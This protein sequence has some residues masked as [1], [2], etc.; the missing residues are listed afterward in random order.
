MKAAFGK[1]SITPPI[2]DTFPDFFF[3]PEGVLDEIYARVAILEADSSPIVMVTLDV[4]GIGVAEIADLESAI[5]KDVIIATERIWITGSHSHSAPILC[6]IDLYGG[7][8]PYFTG[9]KDRL[10]SLIATLM[11]QLQPVTIQFGQSTCDFNV[12]RRLIDANGNCRMAPNPS[13]VVDKSVPVIAFRRVDKTLIGILFSYCC[14][15]TILLGP[16]ISGDYPGWAQNTLEKKYD[17]AVA[18]FLPGV[19]GNVRPYLN[20]GDHFRPGTESEAISCGHVLAKAVED[21]IENCH[22]LTVNALNAWRSTP[23][24][25][26][27]KPLSKDELGKIAAQSI[28]FQRASNPTQT[29]QDGF[30]IAQRQWVQKVRLEQI[31]NRVPTH[32]KYTFSRL[33]LGNLNLVGLSGEFFLEYG[34]HAQL[35]RGDE[36]TLVFGYTQG[37]QTYVPTA[38]ALVQGGYEVHAYK[39]W[40]QSAPFKI[41][42]EDVVKNGISD[43]MSYQS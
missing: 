27:D 5:S 10:I 22:Y 3:H 30:N 9:L 42:V 14:H 13:G 1:I 7:F 31:E 12:N 2:N 4:L 17:S 19:F 34:I 20:S 26:L 6:P 37:C 32:Q 43:L 11:L 36:K 18:L 35:Q 28:T 40:K 23:H 21:G 39:R 8:S 16:K 33:Q 29:W 38:E 24:L 41:E 15:P 25:P